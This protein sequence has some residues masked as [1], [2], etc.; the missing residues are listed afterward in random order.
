MVGCTAGCPARSLGTV[1]LAGASDLQDALD[2]LR[3]AKLPVPNGLIARSMAT[4]LVDFHLRPTK[5]TVM[6]RANA[7]GLSLFA[8]CGNVPDTPQP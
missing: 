5:I 7:D 2:N 8:L 3:E 4:F 6:N 1:A